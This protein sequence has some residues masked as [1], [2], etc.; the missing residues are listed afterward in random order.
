MKLSTNEKAVSFAAIQMLVNDFFRALDDNRI[1]DLIALFVPD[2]E[3]ARPAGNLR[4]PDAI[5]GDLAKRPADRT[6]RHLTSNLR[7]LELAGN[8]C[9]FAYNLTTYAG[10]ASG[11][12]PLDLSGPSGVLDCDD[13]AVKTA[14]DWRFEQRSAKQIF[15]RKP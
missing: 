15:R 11:E 3:W 14:D 6:S 13:V 12:G 7:I 1:D 5:R 10:F 8:R 2:G 9:R 4:G